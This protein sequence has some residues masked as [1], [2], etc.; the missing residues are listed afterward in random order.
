MNRAVLTRSGPLCTIQDLGRTTGRRLG[1]APG[2]AMD[3]RAYLWANRLLG[4]RPDAPALEVT[5]GGAVIRFESATTL[6]ITGADCSAEIDGAVLPN[7]FTTRVQA[8]QVLRLGFSRSGMRAY[9]AFPGGL[10]APRAFGSASVVVRE[11]LD[12]PLGRAMTDG[13]DLRWPDDPPTGRA[14]GVPRTYVSSQSRSLSLPLIPG[15]EWHQFS[16]LDRDSFW[17]NEWTVAS[18]SDRVATRLEGPV[19]RSGPQSLD[20]TP[21]VD[22]TVQVPGNGTPLVFMRDRPTI[23]GYPKLGTVDPG[24]LDDLAQ[25]RPGTRIRFVRADPEEVLNQ[26]RERRAF[27]RLDA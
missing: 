27:F 8:G 17:S 26:L 15:Y 2:G 14:R 21:L 3:R 18:A 6:A 19:L 25:A 22:G 24:A 7:G 11:G 9:I 20:S 4:N 10:D 5:L 1:L 16:S 12:G 23:G 13:A